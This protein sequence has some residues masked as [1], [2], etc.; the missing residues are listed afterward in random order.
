[1]TYTRYCIEYLFKNKT[2]RIYYTKL[3]SEDLCQF[4]L[5]L[6]GV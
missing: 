3:Q 4:K 5:K 1:M 2:T 6:Q